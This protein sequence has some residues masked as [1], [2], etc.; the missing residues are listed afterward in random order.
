[1]GNANRIREWRKKRGLTQE[2]LAEITGLSKEYVSR[3]ERGERNVSLKNHAK[4]AESLNVN[5]TDL[6]PSGANTG[7]VF[8]P[9]LAED[10]AEQ[11]QNYFPRRSALVPIFAGKALSWSEMEVSAA[12]V[13]RVPRPWFLR[14]AAE[15]YGLIVSTKNMAP[16]VEPYDLVIVN[17]DLPPRESRETLFC[18]RKGHKPLRVV[19]ARLL[20]ATSVDWK[21]QE[22]APERG[23][24]AG[25][26]LPKAEW[27]G[28]Y[29]IVAKIID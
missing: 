7:G 3:M 11:A 8:L 12:P 25:R 9:Q 18:S 14:E 1:M 23:H 20:D 26:L 27:P 2:Q 15:V 10:A 16:I 19:I 22:L 21:V 6:V 24:S 29:P 13:D 4:L 5:Q 17:E 28:A